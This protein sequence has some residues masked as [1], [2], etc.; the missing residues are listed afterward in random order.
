MYLK[1]PKSI[2]LFHAINKFVKLL[3]FDVKMPSFEALYHPFHYMGYAIYNT[4]IFSEVNKMNSDK[5][6]PLESSPIG[7]H[8]ICFHGKVFWN[9]FEYMH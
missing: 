9:D 8:D 7:V 1:L 5:T 4:A 3:L 2:I 6:V